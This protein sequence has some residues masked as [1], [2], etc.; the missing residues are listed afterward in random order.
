MH[1]ITRTPNRFRIYS[2]P[3]FFPIL[4]VSVAWL[5]FAARPSTAQ[6]LN[7]IRDQ[8]K[9]PIPQSAPK[10]VD[11]FLDQHVAAASSD[12][13]LHKV[14]ALNTDRILAVGDRGLV[15]LSQDAGRS[16]QQPSTGTSMNLYGTAAADEMNLW[17]VGGKIQ[18]QSEMSIGVVLHSQDSGRTW[19]A[20]AGGN[21]PR[22][23]GIAVVGNSSLI[24][25]GD[26]SPSLGSSLFES[27]DGGATWQGMPSQLG[28]IQAAARDAAGRFLAVDRAGQALLI[29]HSANELPDQIAEPTRPVQGAEFIA[30]KWMVFG[31]HGTLAASSDG[32]LWTDVPLPLSPRARAVFS[33]RSCAQFGDHVWLAGYPGSVMLHSADRGATWKTIATPGNWPIQSLTFADSDRGWAVT[34]GGSIWATRDGGVTWFA[35]RLVARRLGLLAIAGSYENIPW[36]ALAESVAESQQTAAVKV[37]HRQRLEESASL[38][39]EMNVAVESAGAQIGLVAAVTDSAFPIPDRRLQGTSSVRDYYRTQSISDR[40][41]SPLLSDDLVVAL[42]CYRPSVVMTDNPNPT[43]PVAGAVINAVSSAVDVASQSSSDLKWMED[44][45]KLTPWKILKLVIRTDDKGSPVQAHAR[46]VAGDAGTE[47]RGHPNADLRFDRQ[48][49]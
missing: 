13:S 18:P 41:L 16:W 8:L 19:K 11:W 23:T 49:R 47:Y 10:V 9:K 17:V 6:D 24:A 43:G 39:P 33:F 42:R 20:I 28:H 31:D 25:W 40:K 45:L 38:L 4:V 30:G 36:Q 26:Y 14:M 3:I 7:R 22:L 2:A 27:R 32:S 15:L 37:L 29:P 48:Q 44:E 5:T 34:E 12:A 46:S 1:S 35:Q 21:I